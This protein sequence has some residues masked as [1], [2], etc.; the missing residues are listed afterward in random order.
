M[1]MAKLIPAVTGLALIVALSGCGRLGAHSVTP[2]TPPSPAVSASSPADPGASSGDTLGDVESDL[3]DA[4]SAVG[5]SS[6]DVT[7][8]DQAAQQ[9]D[10]P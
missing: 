6:A 5:Q 8:G 1:R 3:N 2:A 4:D 9:N 10:S 7:D